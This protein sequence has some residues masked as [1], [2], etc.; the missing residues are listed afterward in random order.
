MRPRLRWPPDPQNLQDEISALNLE[1][2]QVTIKLDDLKKDN[3]QLLQR[4]LDKMGQE[5]EDM[6]DRS[7][8]AEV[9]APAPRRARTARKAADVPLPSLAAPPAGRAQEGGFSAQDLGLGRG[10]VNGA[11]PAT[12]PEVEIGNP[13]AGV[14]ALLA[15]Q[16]HLNASPPSLAADLAESGVLVS[17]G[18]EL[19]DEDEGWEEVER[20]A[21]PDG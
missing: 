14:E 4:W 6:N 10:Q 9:R 8:F 17:P 18:G 7:G 20:G 1:L 11:P 2:T 16:H 13:Q 21:A 15:G 5:V 3:G 19:D 12:G